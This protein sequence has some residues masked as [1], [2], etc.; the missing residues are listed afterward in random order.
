[1]ALRF[2]SVKNDTGESR[3]SF[4][5]TNSAE[6]LYFYEVHPLLVNETPPAVLAAEISTGWEALDG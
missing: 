6:R 4:V 2:G 5:F 3:V 1:M